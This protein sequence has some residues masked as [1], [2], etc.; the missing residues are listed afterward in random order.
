MAEREWNT[1]I[2]EPWNPLIK[3]CLSAVD[4]HNR[5]YFV[6]HDPRHLHQAAMLRQYV[7]ELKEWIVGCEQAGSAESPRP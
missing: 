7:A 6:T 4:R 1:P 5:L 3:Q 2:R